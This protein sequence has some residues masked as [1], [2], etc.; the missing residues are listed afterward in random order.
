MARGDG[1]AEILLGLLFLIGGLITLFVEAI[2]VICYGAV[3]FGPI[4]MISGFIKAARSRRPAA[5]PP[6]YF[7]YPPAAYAPPPPGF[8]VG[9]AQ[10]PQSPAPTAGAT[11]ACAACGRPSPAAAR[12]C[13]S[14]GSP[15]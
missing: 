6:A 8:P 5:I 11:K 3:I 9:P 4:L 2:P 12:F 14:C 7:A 13:N 10:G 15:F 1:T